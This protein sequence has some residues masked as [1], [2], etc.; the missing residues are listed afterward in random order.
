MNNV[1]IDDMSGVFKGFL[2]TCEAV[3]RSMG[4]EGKLALL[5]S[6]D[7]TAPPSVSKDG[8]SIA[9]NIRFA[10]KANNFGAFLAK[11]IAAKTL[12]ISGDNTTSSLVFGKSFIEN[13]PDTKKYNKAVERG[14]NFAY[15]ESLELLKNYSKPIDKKALERVAVVASNNDES[16]G[17]I[18]M[19]AYDTVGMEGIVGLKRAS[20]TALT[21]LEVSKGMKLNKGYHT[22]FMINNNQ[23]VT[24]EG[25]DVL[26]VVL[27]AWQSDESI[28]N[29]ISENRY[30]ANNQ[31]ELQPILLLMEK[32]EDI[33]FVMDLENFSTKKLYDICLVISP[34]LEKFKKITNLS[35]VALYT[36]G[37]VYR[38]EGVIKAGKAN[39]VVCNH[40]S[41]IIINKNISQEVGNLIAE[42]KSSKVQDDYTRERIQRLESVSCNIMVGGYT[43]SEIDE[44]YDLIDDGLKSA[45]SAIYEGYVPG[46]GATLVFIA[47]QMEKKF[48][49]P[50]EQAGYELIKMVLQEPMKQIVKN[51][52]REEN[53][54]EYLGEARKNFG[55]GYNAKT[56]KLSNLEE[57][58]ILDSVKSLRV[59]F[60]NAKSVCEKLLN[61]AVVVLQSN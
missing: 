25:D 36:S 3:A 19:E 40:D 61:V 20:N 33:A 23:N 26:V 16:L 35:D 54:E 22:P 53:I 34:D 7:I 52:R 18:I 43:Q 51:A 9:L 27:E 37:E 2:L 6:G 60:N 58:G 15:L 50:D 4:A 11:Q 13:F 10:D 48:D 21:T 47:N 30:R 29:F 12:E 14:L 44:R 41:T 59:A 38:P 5:E 28:K 31:N 17:R 32:C 46:G 1:L 39:S 55:F 45:K 24:W 42:L 57:D 56:D 49:N 8:V